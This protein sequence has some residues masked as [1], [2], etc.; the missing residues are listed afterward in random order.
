MKE[1]KDALKKYDEPRRTAIVYSDEVEEYS[2]VET[3]DDYPV[4]IFLSREGYFKK[5]TPLS[6]RMGG[7]Q[8]YKEN[9]GPFLSFEAT[10]ASEL[11][12]FTD[13]QQVYKTR[14]SEFSDTKASVLGSYL[15]TVLNMDEGE[16]V[17]YLLTPGDYSGS[18]MFFFENGK[19]ARIP[20]S[21]YATKTNRKKLSGA[22]SDKSPLVSVVELSDDDEVAAYSTDNR[23]LVFSTAL[24]IPKASRTAQGVAVMAL[25]KKFV[26]RDARLLASTNIKNISRYRVRT[27]PAAGALLKEEDMEEQQIQIDG[28]E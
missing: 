1:L 17:V 23:C 15:P 27:L 18:V 5:I 25:K 11:L 13:K 24:T 10:N 14:A 22:Y 21:S 4:N 26:L 28:M 19:A 20:L 9:D 3:V 2:E 6:L 12:V 8:K 16:N 7:E